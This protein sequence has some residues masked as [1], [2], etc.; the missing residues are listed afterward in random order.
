MKSSRNENK[1]TP[2]SGCPFGFIFQGPR[3]AVLQ[4]RGTLLRYACGCQSAEAS[5][6]LCSLIISMAVSLAGTAAPSL[7]YSWH[8]RF[9]LHAQDRHGLTN[10]LHRDFVDL[11]A[12]WPRTFIPNRTPKGDEHSFLFARPSQGI[13]TTLPWA[14]ARA[15][16]NGRGDSGLSACRLSLK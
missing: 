5:G 3:K 15:G 6:L 2:Q 1:G 7:H 10:K 8:E 9:V 16:N 11:D 12:K 14:P 13:P 4:Q